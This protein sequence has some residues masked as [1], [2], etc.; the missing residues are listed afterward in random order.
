[1]DFPDPQAIK[2]RFDLIK[3][4]IDTCRSL[5]SAL[6]KEPAIEKRLRTTLDQAEK[7]LRFG[8][9]QLA[10]ALGYQLCKAHFPPVPMLKNRV[11]AATATEI[12]K[13]PEC[14][15]ESPSP[16]HFEKLRRRPAQIE[17]RSRRI[18]EMGRQLN[19]Y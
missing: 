11:D 1:M 6:K 13:C 3:S 16:E 15:F 4:A 8:E 5:S 18:A 2:S 9:A 17:A 14:G 7:Q 10:Q 19:R 12:H